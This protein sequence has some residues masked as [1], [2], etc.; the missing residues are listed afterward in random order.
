MDAADGDFGDDAP[1]FEQKVR[2]LTHDLRHCLYV[3]QQG[4]ELL[5]AFRAE[6]AKFDDT[7]RLL[8]EEQAQAVQLVEQFSRL[9]RSKAQP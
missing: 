6:P 7:L 5:N 8:R 2:Q 1:E 4:M 3:L 9:A